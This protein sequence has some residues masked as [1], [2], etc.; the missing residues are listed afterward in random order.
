MARGA[1]A[2]SSPYRSRTI[3]LCRT[4]VLPDGSGSFAR[5]DPTPLSVGQL[6]T[7]E[8]PAPAPSPGPSLP[9]MS[10]VVVG[11]VIAIVAGATVQ[12]IAL[13]GQRAARKMSSV[14]RL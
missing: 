2:E 9:A 12:I 3:V 11:G 13:V 8:G 1:V 7:A 5:G 14:L 10:Q 4:E 6:R